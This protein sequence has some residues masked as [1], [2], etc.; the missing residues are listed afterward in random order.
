MSRHLDNLKRLFGKLQVR[1]GDHDE[2]V[3]QVKQELD[4]REGVE[5]GY[6]H[7]TLPNHDG[8]PGHASRSSLE[9]GFMQTP[10]STGLQ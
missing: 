3:L 8:L 6:Q 4:F 10:R 2:M 5:S 9:P 1:Y 7:S